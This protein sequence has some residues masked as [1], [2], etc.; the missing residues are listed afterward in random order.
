MVP[1]T[2]D[3][4]DKVAARVHGFISD[5]KALCLI[6]FAKCRHSLKTKFPRVLVSNLIIVRN[7]TE[8]VEA[9]AC[10]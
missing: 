10:N 4:L 7:F 3:G 2:H 1:L 9:E 8:R 5:N 6:L